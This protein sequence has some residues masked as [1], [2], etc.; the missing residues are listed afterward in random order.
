MPV[1]RWARNFQI[2]QDDIEHLTSLLLEKEQPLSTEALARVIVEARLA[3]E[4]AQIQERFKDARFYNP[5]ETYEVG[6]RIVFPVFDYADGIVVDEREGIN[7]DYEPFTVINVEFEGKGKR[8]R[9]FASNLSAPHALSRAEGDDFIQELTADS[10]TADD[11][12]SEAGDMIVEAVEKTLAESKTLVKVTGKWFPK[13]LLTEV[14]VGHLNLAEAVLDINGGGPMDT[15]SIIREIGG[16][17]DGSSELQE[18]SLNYVLKDDDRFDE[19][20]PT[21]RV[22]WFLTR[23]EPQEVQQTPSFLQY[24]AVEYDRALLDPEA[25]VLER[26][27]DDELSPVEPPATVDRARVTLIYPHRRVGTL[28][29]TASMRQI[30]PTARQTPRVYVTIVDGQDGEEYPAWVVRQE[31]YIYG[32]GAFYRKHQLPVGASLTAAPDEEPGKI[33]VDFNA[34]RPRTEWVRLIT[35]HNHQIGFE[36]AKRAIG[37][38][39]DDLVILG[40]DDLDAVDA[41]FDDTR[42]QRKPLATIIAEVITALTRL[43]PQGTV[44]AKTIY[45]AVNVVRRYPPGPILATL[46]ANLDFQNV[47]GH[48]WKLT[49]S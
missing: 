42:H 15:L 37:A 44:H 46:I 16:L 5:A 45:S 28:P 14:D 17:G 21:G 6:Q 43:S 41:L 8:V 20:G 39:Y 38:D 24:H 27:I 40:A 18:F 33:V 13:D 1:D 30:F 19:V 25:L 9:A 4:A 31:R 10:L 26:E 22:L 34:Y 36:E 49:D 23:F 47:G 29:L 11:I 35:P 3:E 12:L 32:L 7:P 48:Y 2:R